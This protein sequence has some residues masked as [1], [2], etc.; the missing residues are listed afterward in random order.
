MGWKESA[1]VALKYKWRD[2]GKPI[3]AVTSCNRLKIILVSRKN[4]R[5]FSACYA[6]LRGVRVREQE[7][8]RKFWGLLGGR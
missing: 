3:K 8:A 7:V 1:N 5:D 2:L 6:W 4:L